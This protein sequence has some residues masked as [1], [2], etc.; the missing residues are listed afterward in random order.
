VGAARRPVTIATFR[1]VRALSTARG[2]AVSAAPF[3]ALN[4]ALHAGAPHASGARSAALAD[5]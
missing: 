2:A 3:H 4:V 1:A 5:A